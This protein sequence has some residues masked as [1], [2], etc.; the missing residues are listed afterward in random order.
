[1]GRI[2]SDYSPI[3]ESSTIAL[4][5]TVQRDTRISEE[6]NSFIV[7]TFRDFMD[8][9]D[10]LWTENNGHKTITE[11][12]PRYK[13]TGV[14]NRLNDIRHINKF[15]QSAN[16]S[17][18]DGEYLIVNVET[19]NARR[20]RIFDK[21]PKPV[22]RPYYLL[23]FILKRVMPKWKLSYKLYYSITGGRNQ[24]LSK[25]ETLGRLY[26]C[27]FSVLGQKRIGYNTWFIT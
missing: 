19:K 25:T 15:L 18:Q 6:L 10:F 23:D 16:D 5:K 1:M 24:V 21:Y 4:N 14:I 8:S 20:E 17:L 3:A 13:G 2:N 22:S 26:S 27:G 11:C 9:E 7:E 12:A